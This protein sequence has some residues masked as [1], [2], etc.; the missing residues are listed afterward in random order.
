MVTTDRLSWFGA[1]ARFGAALLLVY[2]T[3]NPTGVSFWHWTLA[4]LLG[5]AP[6]TPEP[7]PLKFIA[8]MILLA[9]WVVFLGATRR[10]LGAKGVLL[11]VALV[12]GVIWL[13]IDQRVLR[14]ESGTTIAHLSLVSLALILA[15]GLSWSFVTRRIS[16]QVDTDDVA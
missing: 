11:A 8:G 15:V 10:S 7:A 14:A 13:L 1:L 4:P 12:G 9:G 5:L 2:G 3:Y 16:G 6:P